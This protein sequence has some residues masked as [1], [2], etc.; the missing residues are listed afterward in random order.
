MPRRCPHWGERTLAFTPYALPSLLSPLTSRSLPHA[1]PCP[2]L[3]ASLHSNPRCRAGQS[4]GQGGP[5]TPGRKARPCW[6]TQ[7][8]GLFLTDACPWQRS[9]AGPTSSLSQ[10]NTEAKRILLCFYLAS[11][12]CLPQG[13]AKTTVCLLQAPQGNPAPHSLPPFQPSPSHGNRLSK[14]HSAAGSARNRSQR[15]LGNAEHFASSRGL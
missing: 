12:A 3:K 6:A 13:E 2:V 1:L 7:A 11:I 4:Q 5:S 9:P 14:G 8:P 10:E 15:R